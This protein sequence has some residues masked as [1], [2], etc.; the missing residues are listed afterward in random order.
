MFAIGPSPP[1]NDPLICKPVKIEA[2][3]DDQTYRIHLVER[4][5][6]DPRSL[7][8]IKIDGPGNEQVVEVRVISHT[9]DSWTLEI[10]GQVQNVLIS[11]SEEQLLI[12]WDHRSF[13]VQVFTQAEQLL[14]QLVRAETEGR[15]TLRA[16]MPGKVIAVL[17]QEGESVQV[18]QGLVII[19]AMKMQNELK[20]P[21]SGTVMTCNVEEGAKISAGDLLFEI[22]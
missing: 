18:G 17:A 10:D 15:A 7:F 19:E 2:K 16:Q 9:R 13:P 22:E 5:E 12:D 4:K 14:R 1:R 3:C 20:S 21:K 11:E 8:E 6:G